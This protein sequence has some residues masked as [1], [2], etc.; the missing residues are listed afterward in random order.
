MHEFFRQQLFSHGITQLFPKLYETDNVNHI[1]CG[2]YRN[3][4]L[5]KKK[6]LKILRN[7]YVSIFSIKKYYTSYYLQRMRATGEF[8]I[9]HIDVIRTHTKFLILVHTISNPIIRS[10]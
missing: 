5:K 3:F 2:L 4:S 1:L 7:L 8:N 6:K 10:L 9:S